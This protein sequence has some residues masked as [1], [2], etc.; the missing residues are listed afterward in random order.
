MET[1]YKVNTGDEGSVHKKIEEFFDEIK[2]EIGDRADG[3]S[4]SRK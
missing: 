3:P 2:K 4:F 1:K